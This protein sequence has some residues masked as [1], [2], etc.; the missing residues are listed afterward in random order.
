MVMFCECL[1]VG[2]AARFENVLQGE[3]GMGGVGCSCRSSTVAGELGDV[4]ACIFKYR[5]AVSAMGSRCFPGLVVLSFSPI[6]KTYLP[7]NFCM[8]V[9]SNLDKV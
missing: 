9:M 5:L 1:C 8:S 3:V 6:A 4:N 2:P 7:G